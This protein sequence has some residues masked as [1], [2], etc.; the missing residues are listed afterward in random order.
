MPR[1]MI[2]CLQTGQLVSTDMAT[3]QVTWKKLSMEWA[4]APFRCPACHRSHSWMK[5]DAVLDASRSTSAKVPL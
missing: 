2:R 4:G 3:D 1:I 5:S